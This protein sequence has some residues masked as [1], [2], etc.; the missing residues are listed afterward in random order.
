METG[1][2]EPKKIEE[3]IT[4]DISVF[5]LYMSERKFRPTLIFVDNFK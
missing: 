4:V 1:A 3:A 2:S 5:T